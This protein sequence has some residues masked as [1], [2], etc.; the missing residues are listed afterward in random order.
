MKLV[1]IPA[2]KF[3]MGSPEAERKDDLAVALKEG[4][5]EQ[6]H[7]VEISKP[8]YLGVYEVTQKQFKEVMGYHTSCFS[9]DGKGKEGIQYGKGTNTAQPAGGKDTVKGMNT[10]DFPVEQVN[11]EEATEFCKKLTELAAEKKT[12]L[13]Y[14]LPTEAEWEYASRGGATSSS[15]FN[16]NGKPSNSLA[17]NQANFNGNSPFDGA[18]NGPNL[19][20]PCKVGSYKPNGFGLFDMHG[21]VWEWCADWYGRDYYTK[22]PRIDPPG[23]REGSSRVMRGGSWAHP[24]RLCRSAI[25]NSREPGHQYYFIGFR[26]AAVQSQK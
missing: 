18:A 3:T 13:T 19:N 20:R 7:E 21:N 15:P 23:P 6:Q 2:G 8:F 5:D 22:S 9:T 12:G 16:I 1:L 10:D 4:K 24:G 14:R 26:V 17:S 11:W 25:R